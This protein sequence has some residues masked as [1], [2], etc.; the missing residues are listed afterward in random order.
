MACAH[1]VLDDTYPVRV[2]GLC[3]DTYSDTIFASPKP[4]AA[5]FNMLATKRKILKWT[6]SIFDPLRP[7]LSCNHHYQTLPTKFL[8]TEPE[9]G[10]TVK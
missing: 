6:L 3:W 4:D 8:A 9:L 10:L 2:L 5:V 7:H 1:N